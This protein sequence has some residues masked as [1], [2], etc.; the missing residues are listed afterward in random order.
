MI[1]C[2]KSLGCVFA[3][4]LALLIILQL[5]NGARAQGKPQFGIVPQIPHSDAVMSV[6]FSPDGARV[7]SASRDKTVKL[8]DVSSGALLRTFQGHSDEVTSVAFS[9]D[10]TRVLSGSQDATM[11]LWDAATGELL[12]TFQ[13][14]SDV[15]VESVA[16]TPDGTRV[17][18]G[19]AGAT[20]EA[21]SLKLWDVATGALLVSFGGQNRIVW[22]V[23]FSPKGDRLLSSGESGVMELWEVS[24]GRLLRTY[25]GRHWPEKLW[26]WL[27][28]QYKPNEAATA[29]AFS[30]DGRRVLSGGADTAMKL[31]DTAT[32]ALLHTFEGHAGTVPSGVAFSPDGAHVLSGG[33]E[34]MKLWDAATGA[35]IRSFDG[36]AEPVTSVAFSPNGALVVSGC[37]DKT[38]KVWNAATGQLV[39]TFA[40]HSGGVASVAFS[41]DGAR[42]LSGQKSVPIVKLWNMATGGLLHTFEG[43]SGDVNSVAFAPDGSR[44]LS[45]SADKTVKLWDVTSGALLRSFQGHS[46]AV[47]SVAFSPDGT[48]VLSGSE[49]ATMKLW[50][51]ATGELSR[52]FEVHNASVDSK[53]ALFDRESVNSVE[54][55]PDGARVVLGKGRMFGRDDAIKLWDTATGKLLRSFDG[56]DPTAVIPPPPM[57]VYSVAFAPD[58]VRLVSGEWNVELW[59]AATG[60]LLRTFAGH[61][62]PVNS[63]AFSPDGRRVLSGSSDNTMKLWDVATG[64]LLRT[65]E[66]HL[67]A[68]WSV[69]FS[70]DSSRVASGSADTTFRVWDPDTGELLATVFTGDNGEWLTQTRQGFF[71]TSE[72]GAEHILSVV[73]GFDVTTMGQVHQSLFNP[74]LVREALAGD[75]D[76]EVRRAAEF[77]NL[78]KVIA[79][80]P[81]PLVEITSPASDNTLDTDLV[82]V[83]TRVENRGK[84][85]G[86]IEWRVNGITTG[87]ANAPADVGP[88]Y[89][90]K[91]TV[92]LDPGENM[93]EV[94]AYNG[95][96]ILASL[97]ARKTIAY[98]GSIDTVRPKLF[99]LA[100]GID[101]YHDEA[102]KQP[103]SKIDDHFPPL[104][105]AVADA[106]AVA[107]EF[108]KAGEGLYAEV[109]VK[110]VINAEAT[111]AGLEQAVQDIAGQ[112]SPRDTFVL[113]AAAHG[114]SNNGRFY[115]IPQDYQGGTDPDAL[116]GHAVDQLRLQDWLA[117]RIKA[118]K[119]L[120][121]LD[122]CE[123]GALT[124]GYAHSRVDGP[125]SDAA[126]GRLHEATG[127]PVLTA[128]SAGKS[129]YENY[130]GHGVFS[131]ALMEALHRGDTNNNGKIEVTELATYVERRVPEL[132]A[133][134]KQSHWVVKGAATVAMRGSQGDNQAAHF[135]STGGDFS[136]V[137]RLQ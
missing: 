95:R 10:G 134:L 126:I 113:Y 19:S 128:A 99:I 98:S 61:D 31:W 21:Q 133:E 107:G 39:R 54:F 129:A 2:S 67:D 24:T 83:S 93:I 11:K 50:D 64:T 47:N 56:P 9:P 111:V 20:A 40:G 14:R 7:V 4:V 1:L 16:F 26:Y 58:G 122:T 104:G 25:G 81:A 44:V 110:T 79:S 85:I 55:S 127:R 78:D 68:V 3:P 116:A 94:V 118:K 71:G 59:D 102:Y 18:S 36:Y 105:L 53:V 109:R 30:P 52:T 96:N 35:L 22:S 32:G 123:S 48:R 13:H 45:G 38:V 124:D 77:I 136:L 82:T 87:V 69:A 131:Y 6:A 91:Q 23:A 34:A 88:N 37:D 5:A 74:D 112:I 80:G 8:W 125:A 89:E 70:P 115:L 73:R 101:N 51:A 103:G 117:N 120:I 75:P 84:G 49:D 76:G 72:K 15:W 62:K 43:H 60:K 63:V 41:P 132:F 86:R 33:Y 108:K 65:F 12:R 130:K 17:L 92:A 42:L 114:Y 135:G 66:G 97:P 29:V 28:G 100:I 121:L 27:T 57:W 137:N 119:A 90:V 106:E 46:K